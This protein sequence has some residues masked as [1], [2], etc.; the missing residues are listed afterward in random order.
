MGIGIIHDVYD[1]DTRFA[2]NPITRV[3]KNQSSK[4][5]TLIQYDHNSER[6]GIW[7]IIY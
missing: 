5:T 7:T 2:I 6:N 1:T 4:K 3:V